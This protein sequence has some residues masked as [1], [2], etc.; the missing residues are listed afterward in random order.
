ML[1]ERIGLLPREIIIVPTPTVASHTRV[2][3]YDH[4]LL[5]A[6]YLARAQGL[7]VKT[8]LYRQTTTKQRGENRRTRQAQAKAAFAV[9]GRL[10]PDKT[11]VLIDDVVTTGATLE[12]GARALKDAGAGDVWV[13]ALA[14]HPLD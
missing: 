2:R 13:A 8:V 9:K 4:T 5:L 14:Y 7:S 3:G 1:S 11:Y 12:Y 6:K 10:M